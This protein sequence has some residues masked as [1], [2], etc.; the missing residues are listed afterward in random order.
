[1]SGKSRRSSVGP[2]PRPVSSSLRRSRSASEGY[3]VAPYCSRRR[4]ISSCCALA[5]GE[6]LPP[7]PVFPEWRAAFA[8]EPLPFVRRGSAPALE[9]SLHGRGTAGAHGTMQGRHAPPCRRRSGRRPP[10]QGRRLSLPGRSDSKCANPACQPRPRAAARHRAGSARECRRR[11]Q[12]VLARSRFDR[13]PLPRAAR[14]RRH[15][16]SARS[17]RGSMPSFP[18]G[19]RPS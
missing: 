2:R 15:R 14:S 6:P 9:E 13:P 10:R 5:S 12:S 3:S 1:M 7:R 16:G 8:V 4:R 18:D 19:W 11:T 17:P